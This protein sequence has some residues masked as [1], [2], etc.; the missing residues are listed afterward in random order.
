MCNSQRRRP[1]S[2][3]LLVYVYMRISIVQNSKHS[4]VPH[5]RNTLMC[6]STSNL[7]SFAGLMPLKKIQ[8]WNRVFHLRNSKLLLK[9]IDSRSQTLWGATGLDV[10]REGA[11]KRDRL[12]LC[13]INFAPS[14]LPITQGQKITEK[15][16]QA[17]NR[18]IAALR[19]NQFHSRR[20]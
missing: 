4:I 6:L 16:I 14:C 12:A 15:R 20:N 11:R 10:I 1:S 19:N 13:R 17:R 3:R 9:N 7:E 8:G 18:S 5:V 2:W